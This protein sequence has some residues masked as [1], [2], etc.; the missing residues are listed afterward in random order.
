MTIDHDRDTTSN[1]REEL[2]FV[3]GYAK[4][5]D[6]T[7]MFHIYRYIGIAL[8][9]NKNTD[10]IEKCEATLV[11]DLGKSFLQ[12]LLAGYDLKKGT[13]II[14]D[15]IKKKYWVP[16]QEAFIFAFKVAVQ[17]YFKKKEECK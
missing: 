13:K 11:T 16:S 7:S 6:G 1:N 5:P 10:I 2:V 12:D 15:Q 8:I 3:S 4:A 17:R 9:V 14:E